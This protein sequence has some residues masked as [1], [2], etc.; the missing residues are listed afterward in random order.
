MISLMLADLIPKGDEWIPF[1]ICLAI[2]GVF[3]LLLVLVIVGTV[4]GGKWGINLL[5]VLNVKPVH[6]P[7]CGEPAPIVRN[8]KNR[9]QAL[10]GG[11]TCEKCGTEYDKW[12][13]A[14]EM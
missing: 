2:F 8:P 13:K 1:V 3:G 7:K 4:M 12:G 5:Q 6:C 10:W 11:G 9:R 14:I